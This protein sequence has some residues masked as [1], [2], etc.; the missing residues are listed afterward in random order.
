MMQTSVRGVALAFGRV[1]SRAARLS[2]RQARALLYRLYLQ[3]PHWQRLRRLALQRA[4]YK[5]AWCGRDCLLHVHH[6]TYC[7]VPFREE[8]SDLVVLC[9][10]CHKRAHGR[11]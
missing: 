2:G 4:G 1:V 10:N 6:T 8:M 5:C 9:P 3:T 11:A 7:R